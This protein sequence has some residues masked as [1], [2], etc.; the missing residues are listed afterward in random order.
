PR[1]GRA[2]RGRGRR[3]R[4]PWAAGGGAGRRPGG[5][6]PSE[7]EPLTVAGDALVGVVEAILGQLVGRGGQR[8]L[9]EVDERLV[10]QL[11]VLG[12]RALAEVP[13]DPVDLEL[14]VALVE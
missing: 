3:T 8:A 13:H 12:G 6:A 11:P 9:D 2:G 5:A 14:V 1:R 10:Q 7:T 4:R